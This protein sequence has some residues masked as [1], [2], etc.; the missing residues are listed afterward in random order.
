MAAGEGSVQRQNGRQ[1]SGGGGGAEL[2]I[3]TSAL[4]TSQEPP[5]KTFL[6]MVHCKEA[7]RRSFVQMRHSKLLSGSAQ[8]NQKLT[9]VSGC[10]SQARWMTLRS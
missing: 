3:V 8:K 6:F 9:C 7:L 4:A 1:I 2:A 5:G 10:A